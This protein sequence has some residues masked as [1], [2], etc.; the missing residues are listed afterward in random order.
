MAPV[1]LMQLFWDPLKR[2]I[3]HLII[4]NNKALSILKPNNRSPKNKFLEK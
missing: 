4:S 1:T 2:L 3:T